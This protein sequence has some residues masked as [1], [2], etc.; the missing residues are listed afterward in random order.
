MDWDVFCESYGDDLIYCFTD[1]IR[2]STDINI[3]SK[4]IQCYPNNKPRVTSNLKVLIRPKVFRMGDRS[5][6][7]EIQQ[8]LKARNKEGK[9]VYGHK[10]EQLLQS[11]GVKQVWSGK[12]KITGLEQRGGNTA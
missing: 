3:P 8:E 4:V 7:K 2:F 1:Y 5:R 6:A 10:L 12:R 9:Q 11:E